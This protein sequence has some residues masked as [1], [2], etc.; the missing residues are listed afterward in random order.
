[1]ADLRLSPQASPP[2]TSPP[3]TSPPSSPPLSPTPSLR[4]R[5]GPLLPSGASFKIFER[6]KSTFYERRSIALDWLKDPLATTIVELPD[7]VSVFTQPRSIPSFVLVPIVC[8]PTNLSRTMNSYSY[9]NI[10]FFF[11]QLKAINIT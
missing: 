8:N 5:D 2:S 1:M 9:F 4:T 6:R 10:F 3:S 7:S 11:D